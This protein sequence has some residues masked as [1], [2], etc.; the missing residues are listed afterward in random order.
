VRW[1]L[2]PVRVF[3][4]TTAPFVSISSNQLQKALPLALRLCQ[5]T[6]SASLDIMLLCWLLLLYY[7]PTN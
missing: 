3:V 2:L 4:L 7:L 5:L 1:T 6:A